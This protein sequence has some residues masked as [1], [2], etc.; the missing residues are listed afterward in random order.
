MA[1]QI[2]LSNVLPISRAASSLAALLRRAR[3]TGGPIVV[4]QK[5]YPTG[6]LLSVDAYTRLAEAAERAAGHKAVGPL[7][8]TPPWAEGEG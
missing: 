2:D 8:F 7:P 5:G 3:E 4:T 1:N 6:V